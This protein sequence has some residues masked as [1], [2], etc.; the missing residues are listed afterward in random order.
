[1]GVVLFY[2]PAVCISFLN[3]FIKRMNERELAMTEPDKIEVE[4]MKACNDAKGKDQRF[5]SAV[6]FL[7]DSRTC[8]CR[9]KLGLAVKYL[10]WHR[11]NSGIQTTSLAK[12]ISEAKYIVKCARS[13]SC[14]DICTWSN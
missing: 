1:M 4:L 5:V 10:F 14:S 13:Q 12:H 7:V 9:F 11:L 8:V 2:F 3:K 6:H